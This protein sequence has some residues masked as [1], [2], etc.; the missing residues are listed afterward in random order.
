[1]KSLRVVAISAGMQNKDGLPRT[2]SANRS[3]VIST[4][5]SNAGEEGGLLSCCHIYTVES[6]ERACLSKGHTLTVALFVGHEL[7]MHR[8]HFPI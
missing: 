4:S 1:V 7:L 5:L 3:K 2:G 8:R 6:I